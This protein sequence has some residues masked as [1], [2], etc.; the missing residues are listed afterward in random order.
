[1]ANDR[2]PQDRPRLRDGQRHEP[3]PQPLEISS[4]LGDALYLYTRFLGRFVLIA[5]LFFGVIALLQLLANETREL[6]PF[7]AFVL[8]SIVGS[9]WL[10]GALVIAVDDA[11]HG[12]LELSVI[13]VLKRLEPHLWRLVGAGL[14][15]AVGVALGLLALII[16]GLVLLSFWSMVT[17]AIVLERRGV[18]DAL[19]RSWRLVKGDGLRVLAVIVVTILVAAVISLVT[20]AIL[21]PLPDRLDTYVTT[22]VANAISLPFVALAWTVMYFELK[23]NRDMLGQD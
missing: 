18:Q 12:K 4:V 9:F 17:P 19:G 2:T 5:A 6:V 11:R 20:G 7:I 22:V 8:A 15:V 14:I 10:H 13:E 23:L 3:R 16:P 21:S 1:M